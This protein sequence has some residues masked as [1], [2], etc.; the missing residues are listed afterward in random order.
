MDLLKSLW[1]PESS[2]SPEAV[3]STD[4]KRYGTGQFVSSKVLEINTDR[5]PTW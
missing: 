2:V 4:K 5:L 3:G 1:K